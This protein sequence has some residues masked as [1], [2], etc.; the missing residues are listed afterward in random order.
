MPGKLPQEKTFTKKVRARNTRIRVRASWGCEFF[1]SMGIFPWDFFPGGG[2]EGIF[3]NPD[4]L[5]EDL[6][7]SSRLSE[8]VQTIIKVGSC[9]LLSVTA[10]HK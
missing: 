6:Y 2:R 8:I 10:H 1:T 4:V 9:F 5:T 7:L 3:R